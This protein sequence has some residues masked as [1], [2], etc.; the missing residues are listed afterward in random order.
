MQMYPSSLRV[1][2]RT[3]NSDVLVEVVGGGRQVPRFLQDH[4]WRL[5]MLDVGEASNIRTACTTLARL[6]QRLPYHGLHVEPAD[7]VA[8]DAACPDL[9]GADGHVPAREQVR[10]AGELAHVVHVLEQRQGVVVRADE[11]LLVADALATEA[12]LV[13]HV[14]VELNCSEW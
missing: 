8:L 2:A 7:G 5:G 1:V 9:A 6:A 3:S 11:L 12:V 4:D 14:E 13:C 10:R